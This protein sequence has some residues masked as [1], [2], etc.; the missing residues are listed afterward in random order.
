MISYQ[1]PLSIVHDI[2]SLTNPTILTTKKLVPN[3]WSHPPFHKKMYIHLLVR[4]HLFPIWQPIHTSKYNWYY[5]I[6]S[7]TILRESALYKLMFHVPNHMSIFFSLGRLSKQSVQVQSP[8][9]HFVTSSTPN[10]QA[11]GSPSVSCPWLLFNIL[12][13]TLP[14]WKPSPPS[15]TWGCAMPW[16]QGTHL[17]WLLTMNKF[18][19]SPQTNCST[20]ID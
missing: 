4:C 15:T 14:I 1:Q 10:P 2:L 12:A 11:G 18:K 17:T 6:S 8:L 13:A 16:W 5:D 3:S 7:T 9:W 19:L 20:Q